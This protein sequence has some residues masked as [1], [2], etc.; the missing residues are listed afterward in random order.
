MKRVI[1]TIGPQYAGKSTFC[2]NVLKKYPGTHCVSRD[3]ILIRMFGTVWLNTYSGGH[4]AAWA[5]LWEE[6]ENYVQSLGDKPGTLILD[7]W[8]AHR[9]EREG[10]VTKLR[11]MGATRVD[12][13][14]F[15]TLLATCTEWSLQRDPPRPLKNPKWADI[16]KSLRIDEYSR[17]YRNFHAQ[18]IQSE[19]IL[20][21]IR[22]INVLDPMPDD[23]LV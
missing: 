5:A 6:V 16:H 21:S 17:C 14:Y 9:E 8:N 23:I 22:V 11:G 2:E 20:D 7:A 18:K 12:G 4:F 13:W 3:K 19:K 10:I 1:L 15:K